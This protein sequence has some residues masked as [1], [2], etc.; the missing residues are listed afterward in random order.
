[1]DCPGQEQGHLQALQRESTM[2]RAKALVHACARN[3]LRI[4][5][6]PQNST[7]ARK[8]AQ[9]S[10]RS[11]ATLYGHSFAVRPGLIISADPTHIT[12]GQTQSGLQTCI[13]ASSKA[14]GT[15]VFN[16]K[17]ILQTRGGKLFAAFA[18]SVANIKPLMVFNCKV[19]ELPNELGAPPRTVVMDFPTIGEQGLFVAFKTS[20][21]K[22]VAKSGVG[23]HELVKLHW[24]LSIKPYSKKVRKRLRALGGNNA[25][26]LTDEQLRA[27]VE[28]DGG[29]FQVLLDI[30]ADCDMGWSTLLKVAVNRTSPDQPCDSASSFTTM[31][32]A[33]RTGKYADVPRNDLLQQHFDGLLTEHGMHLGKEYREAVLDSILPESFSKLHC[34]RAFTKSFL[35][36][37]GGE[38]CFS[39][40]VHACRAWTSLNEEQASA[41]RATLPALLDEWRSEGRVTDAWFDE[42]SWPADEMTGITTLDKA[43]SKDHLCEAHGWSMIVNNAAAVARREK[44]VTDAVAEQ[45]RKADAKQAAK[46]HAQDAARD[47]EA[48]AWEKGERERLRALHKSRMEADK[49]WYTKTLQAARVASQLKKNKGDECAA[50]CGMT[51]GGW[52]DAGMVAETDKWGAEATAGGIASRRCLLRDYKL[53][54]CEGCPDSGWWCP[55]CAHCCINHESIRPAEK[56]DTAKE[57]K[58]AQKR[59]RGGRGNR[60]QDYQGETAQGWAVCH[61]QKLISMTLIVVLIPEHM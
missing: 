50:E 42:N 34:N 16:A 48:A 11:R 26:Y 56:V 14:G 44:R 24:D 9:L 49:Q 60:A 40:C 21:T 30:A 1:M 18:A 46:E 19:R 61:F 43:R 39:K 13:S 2:L 54:S 45:V 31:K 41:L 25:E 10:V 27:R 6:K 28:M 51:W 33:V 8:G 36:D 4:V 55:Q 5:R 17:Y 22:G 57:K 47:K 15:T 3:E 38:V 23:G 12:L 37:Y 52:D 7:Q 59:D 29:D 53:V 35:A 32:Q 20:G 58:K